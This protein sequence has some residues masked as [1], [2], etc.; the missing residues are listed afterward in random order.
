MDKI[1]RKCIEPGVEYFAATKNPLSGDVV[2]IEGR[3]YVW[4]FDVGSHP[5]LTEKLHFD[6]QVKIVLSHFHQDHITNLNAISFDEVLVGE[7]TYKYTKKG[8]VVKEELLF[9]DGSTKI[10]IMP[11]PSSHAKG[12]LAMEVNDTYLCVGDA[13]YATMKSGRV[14]YNAGLLL[15]GIRLLEKSVADTVLI[16]HKEPLMQNK[17]EFLEELR[18]IYKRRRGNEAYIE[19]GSL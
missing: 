12:S 4:L 6:K 9:F 13:F 1:E 15:E 19:V 18:A 2:V 7:N 8:T 3:E 10:N 14:V 17:E 11:I 16:S 5:L